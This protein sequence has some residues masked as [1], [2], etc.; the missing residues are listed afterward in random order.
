[1]KPAT[2]IEKVCRLFAAFRQ[3]SALGVT[4]LAQKADLLPSDAHRIATS[5]KYFGYLGQDTHTKKYR[6]GLELLKLGH[7]V[8]QRIELRE[9]ARPFLLRLAELTEATANLAIF[10]PHDLEIIFVDQVDWPSEVQIRLRIGARAS[11]HA[12]SV[13]KVLTAFMDPAAAERV[14]RKKGVVRKTRNTIV[15]PQRLQR[16]FETIRAQGYA[17]DREEAVEGACCI[18]A[19]LRDHRGEVTAAVSISMLA[20]R[21]ASQDERP[22]VS[23]V[24]TSAAKISAA[25]GWAPNVWQQR[26]RR[27]V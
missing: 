20:G 6:L 12:T 27:A 8:H 2:S 3:R 17:W 9:V 16:E 25:L 21:I 4:E 18:G 19:P 24:T 10:D 7:L 22:L 13:G 1:M 11:P 15:D 5:L 23:A 26:R 14:L